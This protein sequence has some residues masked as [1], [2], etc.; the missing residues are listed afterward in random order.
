MGTTLRVGFAMGGGNSL[1]TF[2]GAALSQALKLL[3][4]RGTDRN[5]EPY[6][7]VEVDVF[8]GASA[9]SLSL[10]LLLRGLVH[11]DTDRMMAAKVQLIAEFGTEF[12]EAPKETKKALIAA[13]V[14]QDVQEEVWVREV[15]LEKLLGRSS[16]EAK[17]RIRTTAGF[18]DRGAVEDLARRYLFFPGSNESGSGSPVDLSKRQ[19]LA[20]RVLFASSLAN[21]N[22]I[23]ADAR[24]EYPTLDLGLTGLLDGLTSRVHN[25]LRVFDL[26][27]AAV[28]TNR[29]TDPEA[30]PRRWCRY[31]AGPKVRDDEGTGRGIGSLLEPKGWSKMA[32][33]SIASAAVPLAFEPVP[34]ERRAYEFGETESGSGSGWPK[35]LKGKDRHVFTY[36]DGGTFNNEPVRE[37]FRM[38][39]FIDAQSPEDDFE[40]LILFVDPHITPPPSTMELKHYGRW[41]LDLPDGLLAPMQGGELRKRSSLDRLIPLGGALLAAVTDESRV[42]E[43]DKVFQTRQRFQI[44]NLMREELAGVLSR[45][46]NPDSL[47]SLADKLRALMEVD[48]T[49]IMIPAG[50]LTL[51]GELRRVIVEEGGLGRPLSTLRKKSADEIR[52]FA[53]APGSAPEDERSLWLQALSFAAVDRVMDLEGKMEGSQL[54]AISPATDPGDPSQLEELP[55]GLAHGFGGFMSELAGEYEVELGRYCAQLFLQAAGRIR[56]KALPKKPD[57]SKQRARY[58][59][60]VR[61]GLELAEDRLVQ[62]I[63]D[64]HIDLLGALPSGVLR[65]LLR[66][67]LATMASEKPRPTTHELRLQVPNMSYEFDG[68]GLAD[69]DLKP[70]KID[71]RFF[72]ITFATYHDGDPKPWDGPHVSGKK[73]ALRV[74][75]GRKGVPTDKEFCRVTLP[76]KAALKEG[77]HLPY[78]VWVARIK[79]GDEGSRVGSDRWQLQDDVVGL[80]KTV[81]T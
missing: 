74:D 53:N 39:S 2:S 17:R 33:T 28:E 40:R 29:L 41:L 66:G 55:G 65:Y 14:L 36:V 25:E 62:L 81:L 42:V 45:D 60:E 63:A 64:S 76:S 50:A 3:L 10:S 27:F 59:K 44:R 43:A 70:R 73:Q 12:T 78:P 49:G 16:R 7:R 58:L 8:S 79:K 20:E 54:V 48:R 80:E 31:H 75:R 26:H 46:P 6:E 52:A 72:L 56:K 9:G 22:P 18:L 57:F 38:A 11:P 1:G 23:L 15:D 19:L 35:S 21:L 4:L 47:E 30:F 51:E 77:Q 71:G 24:Q 68:R 37:A 67:R 13:Q 34:L 69:G 5:G 61:S 32:A